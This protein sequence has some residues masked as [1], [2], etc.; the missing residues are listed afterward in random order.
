M[1]VWKNGH[2]VDATG[3][4]DADERGVLLGDGLFETVAV[5][6]GRP[7][8]LAAHVARLQAGAGVLGMPMPADALVLEIAVR[9][10]AEIE[11]VHEGSARITLLRGPAPRGV[12][13]PARP[14]P[15][16]L[17]SVA[18][19]PL[20]LN[21]PLT[22]IVATT[23]R[24][25][26]RSPLAGIKSTNYLDAILAR[27]E[28]AHAGADEAIMLNTRDGV[29]EATAANVFCVIGGAIMTPPIRD[30]ALPGIMR[31]RVLAIEEVVERTLS[32][33]DLAR[34]DELFLTS[35]LSIRPLVR[36]NGRTVGS[37]A[38]GPVAVRLGDLPRRAD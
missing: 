24:R 31:G 37:G 28:A 14:Q 35:S 21:Q 8:S 9:A 5:L 12:L 4:I 17:V 30:G 36:L 19:G 2:I 10:V 6:N 38:P 26:E 1:K 3:A 32:V 34:A 25:N 29:A 22:A 13:P 18:A 33:A 16:L 27:A 15:T 23:T 7:L 11:S 20:G